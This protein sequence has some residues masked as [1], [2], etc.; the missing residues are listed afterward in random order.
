MSRGKTP[1]TVSIKQGAPRSN[2]QN[3]L[4]HGYL[5]QL[6]DQ[7]DMTQK[8]YEARC[9]LEIGVPILCAADDEYK[10]FYLEHIA[11]WP[12]EQQLKMM[13]EPFGFPVSRLMKTK[14]MV[15]YT[16]EIYSTYTAQGLVLRHPDDALR[17]D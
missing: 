15:E 14:Q 8:E 11:P 1:F 3:R 4:Y 12:Y 6:A 13:S 5:R 2:A 17:N 7:G 16:N 10:A 9:K